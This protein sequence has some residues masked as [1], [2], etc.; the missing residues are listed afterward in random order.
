MISGGMP[1][2]NCLPIQPVHFDV[3]PVAPLRAKLVGIHGQASD[4]VAGKDNEVRL[5]CDA[6]YDCVDL[7]ERPRVEGVT[8]ARAGIA[9]Q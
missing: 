3:Q 5:R 8:N 9:I 1:E 6:R 2:G 4:L 7:C